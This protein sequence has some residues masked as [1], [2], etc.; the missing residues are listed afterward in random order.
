MGAHTVKWYRLG[1]TASA[2]FTIKP[3][4]KLIPSSGLERGDTV[5]VSLRG[6]AANE[7]VRVRWKNGSSWVQLA[8]IVTS[9]TGSKNV[10]V[11]VPN[12][13][14]IGT[15]SVR[16]DGNKGAAAQTN[17]VTVVVSASSSSAARPTATATPTKTATR[18][19]TP[20]TIQAT[21]TPEP[22][23][24]AAPIEEPGTPGVV[25][26]ETPG[27]DPTATAAPETTTETAPDDGV[28]ETPADGATYAI[29]VYEWDFGTKYV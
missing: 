5:N 20:T 8:Q 22:T 21:V 12:F 15:N 23:M 25:E 10:N 3:R 9:S 2:T 11:T 29:T 18:T 17:A 16:G 19:P 7:T 4:I 27:L 24:T 13:A 26:S 28:T 1:R 6:F 14:A